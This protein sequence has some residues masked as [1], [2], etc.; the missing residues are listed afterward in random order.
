MR[1]HASDSVGDEQKIFLPGE[2]NPIRPL[3]LEPRAPAALLGSVK[4]DEDRIR[5]PVSCV[6]K[7]LVEGGHRE[8]PRF[9][10]GVVGQMGGI[11][12]EVVSDIASLLLRSG[13][14][15][16]YERG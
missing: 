9:Q 11:R 4:S 16:E 3:L 2:V 14:M 10:S 1:N 6:A 7:H 15:I 12:E 8:L 13:P 5:P